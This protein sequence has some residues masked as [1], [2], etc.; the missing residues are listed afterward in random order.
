MFRSFIGIRSLSPLGPPLV[1]QVRGVLA[2]SLS[3][4]ATAA[5][6]S[7]YP[8]IRLALG[9]PVSEFNSQPSVAAM[10]DGLREGPASMWGTDDYIDLFVMING[11]ERKFEIRNK[12]GLNVTSSNLE[13]LG[14]PLGPTTVHSI[15]FGT[16]YLGSAESARAYAGE[17]CQQ[18]EEPPHGQTPKPFHVAYPYKKWGTE[19]YGSDI[20]DKNERI[21]EI[22]S[23]LEAISIDVKRSTRK[24][25]E[26]WRVWINLDSML[27]FQGSDIRPFN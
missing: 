12:Y 3:I 5:C 24:D 2:L 21:C 19:Y 13:G 9:M 7:S 15:S 1:A 14:R 11:S 8:T 18:F 23:G 6:A 16:D 22:E 27:S 17:L 25:D 20:V 26:I 10:G 4:S